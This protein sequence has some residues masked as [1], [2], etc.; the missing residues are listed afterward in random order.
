ML[1]KF[2]GRVGDAY[3]KNYAIFGCRELLEQICTLIHIRTLKQSDFT[4][5]YSFPF[6][7]LDLLGLLLECHFDIFKKLPMPGDY[8][9]QFIIW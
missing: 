7:L 9:A 8:S 2:R 6:S 5:N 1:K 4:C 3:F